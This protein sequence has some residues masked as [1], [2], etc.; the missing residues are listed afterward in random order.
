MRTLLAPLLWLL[1][2]GLA[3]VVLWRLK[4]GQRIVLR[5]RWAPNVVRMVAVIL[6]VFGVGDGDRSAN[7]AEAAP[8]KVLP[9]RGEALPTAVTDDVVE[10]WLTLQGPASAEYYWG[11]F[12]QDFSRTVAKARGRPQQVEAMR[13]RAG[14]LPSLLQ[15]LVLADI[16]AIAKDR[17]PAPAPDSK[18]LLV[19]DEVERAALYD[20]WLC[21]YLWRK[22][23]AGLPQ[24]AAGD[25]AELYARLHRHARVADALIR[26]HAVVKPVARAPRAWMSKAGPRPEQRAVMQAQAEVF[27]KAVKEVRAEAGKF[28]AA[29]GPGTW[30]RDGQG[31]F[32][33][34]KG[35]AIPTLIR[36]GK[37]SPVKTDEV[38]RFGRLDLLE[39]PPGERPVV[40]EHAWLGT[41]E[42]PAGKTL[43]VWELP[44]W[45]PNG[46]RAQLL[47]ATKSAL[48]GDRAAAEQLEKV[49]PLAH[50]FIRDGLSADPNGKGAPRLRMILSLF[51]DTPMPEIR[52]EPVT[53]RGDR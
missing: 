53:I 5:G 46:V 12:K 42:L 19:L 41:V 40:M 43:S 4:R 25:R 34:A 10:G 27:R 21:A 18:L 22:T 9:E 50:P 49:L 20:H 32:R 45:S 39:T 26:A 48:G 29:T 6:V 24:E 13:S 35:S 15:V 52:P 1:A 51:D 14:A 3:L 28:Y 17:A 30:E 23:A 38:F 36:A 2:L 8:V 16:E 37:K 33:L 44:D 31:A 11:R 47:A 7:R